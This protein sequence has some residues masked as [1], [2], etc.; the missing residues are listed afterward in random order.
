MTTDRERV[1]N[2]LAGQ[3]VDRFPV[4]VPYIMLLQEDQWCRLTGQPAWTFYEWLLQEPCDHVEVYT[5]FARQLPFD[6]LQPAYGSGRE[7]RASREVVERDGKWYY[8][9]RSTGEMELLDLDLHHRHGGQNQER[10]VF[11]KSDVDRLVSATPAEKRIASGAYDFPLEA[12]KVLGDRKFFLNGV[13]GTFYQCTAYVGENNLFVML[14][15]QP[16]LIHYLSSK[17]LEATIESIRALAASG[18]DAIYIDDALATCDM[19][20]VDFYERFSMPY[21]KAM[22]D[23]IHALGKPAVLIYFGGVADRVEQIASLGAEGLNVETSMKSYTNDL[24]AISDQ[25]G[26]RMCL[27]GNLDP[28][29]V[30]QRGTDEEL[31]Q[32][33]AEQVAIGRRTGRFIVSTGSPITPETPLSRIR[34]FIDLGRELSTFDRRPG[35]EAS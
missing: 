33:I 35:K 21:V 12:K 14:Y 27:W 20:S 4:A 11:D 34:H 18:H 16:D 13:V 10:R 22:I 25:I 2:V 9:R 32:A 28:V 30:V 15:D 3:P 8:R 24:G 6:I 31:R 19:I 7:W 26:D 17:I 5:E 1:F 29:G 23:E